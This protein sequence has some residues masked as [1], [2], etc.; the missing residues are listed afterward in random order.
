MQLAAKLSATDLLVVP[1]IWWENSPLSILEALAARCRSWS[2]TWAEWRDWF[3]RGVAAT[4][5]GSATPK[6][7]PG[8]SGVP[9]NA[10][11]PLR[12]RRGGCGGPLDRRRR[13][14][15]PTPNPRIHKTVNIL[16]AVHGYPP[17]C[18]GGTELY[19][20]KLAESLVSRGH[21]SI[22]RRGVA[23]MVPA[24]PRERG[25]DRWD[26]RHADPPQRPLQRSLG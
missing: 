2:P 16:L 15:A 23:P 8:P 19:V 7:W 9:R 6:I 10:G 11:P 21:Q 12:V 26:P 1:S 25:H 24:G 13:A 5:S 17:E 14:R 18:T 20:R 22:G 4:V 3:G